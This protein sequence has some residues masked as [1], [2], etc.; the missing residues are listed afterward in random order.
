M[1]ETLTDQL[2]TAVAKALHLQFSGQEPLLQQLQEYLRDKASLLLFDNLEHLLPQAADF[3]VELLQNAPQ[4]KMI[5]TS[6]HLLNLQAETIVRLAG[7]PAPH[8]QEA[9]A[10]TSAAL[11][12]YSSV[13]L[14]VERAQRVYPAFQATST[15]LA[16]IVQICHLVHGLP[17]AIE[18]AASQTRKYTCT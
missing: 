11:L 9:P 7:L 5:A 16:V 2:V 13:A 1:S 17:L 18:L 12:V 15:N 10:L 14:F 3:L 8:P 4:L 6:R